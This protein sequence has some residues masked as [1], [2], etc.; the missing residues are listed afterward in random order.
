[1]DILC[2]VDYGVVGVGV[3]WFQLEG[4]AWG[5]DMLSLR[6]LNLGSGC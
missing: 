4:A 1:M 2:V 3:R 6:L 5:T